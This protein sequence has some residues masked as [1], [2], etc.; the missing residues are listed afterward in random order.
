MRVIV[1]KLNIRKAPVEDFS[2][3]SNVVAKLFNGAPFISV[4]EKTNK[5]GK[6]YQNEKGYWA[7]EV[8]LGSPSAAEKPIPDLQS[9][10]NSCFDGQTLKSE[11]NYGALLEIE[12]AVK[13]AGGQNV[14][15]GIL[16]HPM[17]TSIQFNNPV[18]APF[19]VNDPL[20]N[21]HGNFIAGIIAGT[22]GIIGFANKCRLVELPVFNARASSGGIDIN[23]VLQFINRDDQPMIVNISNKLDAQY[24]D[25]IKNF[26]PNKIVVAAAGI[27]EQLSA[28]IIRDPASLDNVIAVGAI[29]KPLSNLPKLNSKVDF[30]LP[31]YN[32]V[33]YGK[34]SGLFAQQ[35]GDSFACAVVSGII[36][37]LIS[38]N[39]VGF[40]RAS[41]KNALNEIAFPSSV[42]SFNSLNLINVTS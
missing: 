1:P 42:E 9:F 28:D 8:G 26:R 35:R 40:D 15:I 12:D 23:A 33:S 4:N 38:S 21:F 29:T 7:W 39:K 31:N 22:T 34:T 32:F 17:S 30:V 16:D 14:T 36:A 6:W 10:L 2:D 3:K 24:N 27:D 20:F 41:I 19:H 11:I 13:I 18:S 25:T 37:L 5:V